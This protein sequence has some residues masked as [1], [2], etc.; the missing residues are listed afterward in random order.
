MTADEYLNNIKKLDITYNQLIRELD[1]IDQMLSL[2]GISYGQPSGQSSD[3]HRRE[4]LLAI[5]VSIQEKIEAERDNIAVKRVKYMN[6]LKV[7]LTPVEY[8]I[9]I[10]K[11][12]NYRSWEDVADIMHYSVRSCKSYGRSAKEKIENIARICTI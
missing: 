6:E 4:K 11:Y 12:F 2:K 1:R 3:P 7:W 8:H 10:E 5:K 9:I